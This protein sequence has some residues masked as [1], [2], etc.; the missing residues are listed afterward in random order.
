MIVRVV[1]VGTVSGVLIISQ[2][3]RLLSLVVFRDWISAT[4]RHQHHRYR[5]D[6]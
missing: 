4:A 3:N 1:C 2:D 5:D 6:T